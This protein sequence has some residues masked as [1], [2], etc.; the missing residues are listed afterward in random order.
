MNCAIHSLKKSLAVPHKILEGFC[1]DRL[2]VDEF[3]FPPVLLFLD[4]CQA[5]SCIAKKGYVEHDYLDRHGSKRREDPG[6][7]GIE[8]L[9]L[10]VQIDGQQFFC[11]IQ[12]GGRF[13][14]EV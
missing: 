8:S 10:T 13:V 3:G 12:D 4:M 5:L 1:Q 7:E 6:D 14:R 9:E 11:H 2:P